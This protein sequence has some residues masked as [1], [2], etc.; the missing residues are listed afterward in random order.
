MEPD[1]IE[2]GELRIENRYITDLITQHALENIDKYSERYKDS[3]QPFYISVH[4]TA[5]PRPVGCRSA[6][7]RVCRD[8]P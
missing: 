4:Y 2:N 1:V 6:S 8:V 3:D 7:G 5:P